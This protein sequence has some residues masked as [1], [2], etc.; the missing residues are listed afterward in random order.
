MAN[1][2]KDPAPYLKR[3]LSKRARVLLVNP[4]V[5]ERRY[6]WLRWNQPMELLR[7][8]SWL[9]A[10]HPG[11]DVRLFDFMLPDNAGAVPRHKVKD[12]WT[13]ADSDAQLWHF[14]QPFEA[15]ERTVSKWLLA[16]KWSP[17]L[18]LVS[19]LTSYWHVSI[20]KLLVKL[21]TLLGAKRRKSTRVCL[22]G[23]YPRLEPRHAE[24]QTDA[25]VAFSKSVDTRGHWPDFPLYLAS[26]GRLPPFFA[27]DI[28]DAHIEEHLERCLA[29]N[30]TSTRD[31]HASRQLAMTVAFFNDDI[32]SPSSRL[33]DVVAFAQA[34]AGQAL[35]EGIAG[36]EPRSLNATRLMQ[37]K[38][39]G[40]RSLFVEHARLPGGG[41][42]VASYQP[43]LTFLNEEEHAK[44]IGRV[45]TSWLSRGSV[46]G[47]VAMGLPDDDLD[48]LVRS[49][50]LVN[51]FFQAVIL[52]PYGYS[53][54]VDP[55]TEASRRRRWPA[56]YASSPQWFPFVGNGSRLTGADYDNLLRWQNVVNKR[57]KGATFDF[58]DTGTVAALVRDTLVAESWKR[59]QEAR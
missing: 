50:L 1:L 17:D 23:N 54:S 39:A 53:P 27:L 47:F 43:L 45:T 57:V 30:N 37:L 42:D 52:K 2:V 31:G 13:G 5:Q 44:K 24:G 12:T 46:T 22:Y 40:F 19:S 14:G 11:I 16:D 28:E 38:M 7:L 56:P 36:V 58:L 4:P 8:S 33:D 25:D 10:A 41:V 59:R 29:F 35:I 6:H 34:H 21:C 32:C 9:K 49:T 18:V 3:H 15:F 51:S 26:D 55:L 20:E 48:D